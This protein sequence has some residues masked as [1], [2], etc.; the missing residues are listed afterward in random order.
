VPIYF[1][2]NKSYGIIAAIIFIFASITDF[3]DGYIARKKNLVTMF[4]SF[5]DP[6]ADKFLVVST[7]IMLL[8]LQRVPDWVVIVL[9]LR[10]MYMMSL[11]LFAV[12]EGITVHVNDIGKWKTTFQMIAIPMLMVYQ[13]WGWF[14]FT[15]VGLIFIFM[16]T[17]LSLLSSIVY[18]FHLG[19]KIKDKMIAAVKLRQQHK[20]EKMHNEP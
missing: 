17:F 12:H 8:S 16:A 14:D 19:A 18:S 6:I 1:A 10:E 20:R 3:L 11:R 4:G 7:L 15:L 13:K 5:L 2:D 9:V